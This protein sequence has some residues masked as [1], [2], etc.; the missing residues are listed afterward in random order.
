MVLQN[1]W[2]NQGAE[3]DAA[4]WLTRDEDNE[5][6]NNG[7]IGNYGSQQRHSPHFAEGKL[8]AQAILTA[9]RSH[10]TFLASQ[11]LWKNATRWKSIFLKIHITP[12]SHV[13]RR[14]AEGNAICHFISW[15]YTKATYNLEHGSCLKNLSWQ[16]YSVRVSCAA[17]GDSGL[18]VPLARVYSGGHSDLEPAMICRVYNYMVPGVPSHLGPLACPAEACCEAPSSRVGPCLVCTAYAHFSLSSRSSISFGSSPSLL[19][20]STIYLRH[21]CSV[22]FHYMLPRLQSTTLTFF[23]FAAAPILPTLFAILNKGFQ[24][25]I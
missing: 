24:N 22:S 16:G 23:I 19:S 5:G 18:S 4:Q 10:P 20:I 13:R 1:G 6:S 9:P 25:V 12:S 11:R 7:V 3:I 2:Q 14:C 17:R 8:L 21:Y 15:V